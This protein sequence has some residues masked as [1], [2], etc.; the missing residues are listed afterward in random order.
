ML[1]TVVDILAVAVLALVALGSH[2]L[3]EPFS[4]IQLKRGLAHST[5]LRASLRLRRTG[6]AY[7]VGLSVLTL[8]HPHP[9]SLRHVVSSFRHRLFIQWSPTTSQSVFSLAFHIHHITL[10]LHTASI[11]PALALSRLIFL[12]LREDRGMQLL[13]HFLFTRLLLVARRSLLRLVRHALRQSRQYVVNDSAVLE[14][15][16]ILRLQPSKRLKHRGCFVFFLLLLSSGLSSRRRTSFLILLRPG[17]VDVH[18]ILLLCLHDLR[19][20]L[21]PSHLQR[22]LLHLH[23]A[24]GTTCIISLE[25][26][27]P[28]APCD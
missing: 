27:D 8:H 1:L 26:P 24:I 28:V 11:H 22:M 16:R 7:Q 23:S 2:L 20:L 9:F 17:V 19:L 25:V 15:L 13:H 6:L 10:A 5:L 12:S 18:D 3:S 14:L 21:L 4:V